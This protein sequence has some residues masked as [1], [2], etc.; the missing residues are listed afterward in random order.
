[1]VCLQV[2]IVY[3]VSYTG[4]DNIK[5]CAAIVK[6]RFEGI[7]GS[8]VGAQA[9]AKIQPTGRE[10]L[11]VLNIR[12][13]VNDFKCPEGEQLQHNQCGKF[14]LNVGDVC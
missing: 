8:L 4:K 13:N 2:K 10:E 14:S 9:L 12:T 7:G 5:A 6:T 3:S 1:V 11:T